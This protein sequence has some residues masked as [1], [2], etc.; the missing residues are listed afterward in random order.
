MAGSNRLFAVRVNMK[1]ID[2]SEVPTVAAHLQTGAELLFLTKNG[3]AVGVV[4]PVTDDDVESMLLGV[5]PQFQQ[6]LERSQQR[7]DTE[8]GLSSADVRQRLGLPP[9]ESGT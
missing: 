2:L 3:H 6:I 5:N 9:I 1:C 7:L 8:G 4:V